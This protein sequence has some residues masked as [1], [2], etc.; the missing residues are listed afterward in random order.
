MNIIGTQLADL[1]VYP[2]A[3]HV[4]NTDKPNPAYNIV[5]KKIY[6]GKGFIN[7]LKIFP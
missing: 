3:R 4:Q 7:G 6:K 1:V 5:E 2:I